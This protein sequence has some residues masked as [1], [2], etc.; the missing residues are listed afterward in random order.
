MSITV[1]PDDLDEPTYW[2]AVER[3]DGAFWQPA[4]DLIHDGH[5]LPSGRS[6]RFA[7]GRNAVFALA[8]QHAFVAAMP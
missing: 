4:P 1:L 3:Q 5:D 7:P 6:Q 2:Q 8:A